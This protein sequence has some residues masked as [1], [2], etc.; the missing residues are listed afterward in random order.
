[1]CEVNSQW[2]SDI[3]KLGLNVSI[4]AS[5]IQ[6]DLFKIVINAKED[7]YLI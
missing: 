7:I 6:H 3:P 1:M 2:G 4:K 5:P